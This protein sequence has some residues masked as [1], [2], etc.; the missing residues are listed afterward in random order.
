MEKSFELELFQ[1]LWSVAG[2]AQRKAGNTRLRSACFIW[3]FVFN[4]T[5]V[6]SVLIRLGIESVDGYVPLMK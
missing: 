2:D 4:F 6:Q 1:P 5:E 3:G